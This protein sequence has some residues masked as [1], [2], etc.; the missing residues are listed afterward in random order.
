M[1]GFHKPDSGKA[2]AGA[3]AAHGPACQLLGKEI[4][5]KIGVPYY[6][7]RIVERFL[8]HRLKGKEAPFLDKPLYRF[9]GVE[10]E[11]WPMRDGK[12]ID[13]RFVEFL[14]EE[15]WAREHW[16]NTADNIPD[17]VARLPDA[18]VTGIYYHGPSMCLVLMHPGG[19]K[20]GI[21]ATTVLNPKLGVDKKG[22]GALGKLKKA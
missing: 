19:L 2:I 7:E 5:K 16:P 9:E 13:M 8:G 20:V 3:L 18:K 22:V 21:R 6:E 4:A 15:V 1:S 14:T 17:A 10:T 12:A 11:E